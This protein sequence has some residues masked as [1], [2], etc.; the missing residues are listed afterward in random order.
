M[1]ASKKQK[2]SETA[3]RAAVEAEIWGSQTGIQAKAAAMAAV[4]GKAKKAA[5]AKDVVDMKIR[6]HNGNNNSN[7]LIKST[8]KTFEKEDIQKESKLD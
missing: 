1:K 5:E 7:Q 3:T 6:N 2:S 4:V 8:T